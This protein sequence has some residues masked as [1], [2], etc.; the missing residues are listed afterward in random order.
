MPEISEATAVPQAL[1]RLRV[2]LDDAYNSEANELGL[3]AQQAEL[4]CA[5]AFHPVAVGELA[6]VLRCDRSNVSRL[7]DRIAQHDLVHRL[8]DEGDGRVSLIELSPRGRQLADAFLARLQSRT[9]RLVHTWSNERQRQ[10]SAMLIELAEALDN[11][12]DSGDA[13]PSSRLES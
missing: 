9:E 2:A 13:S 7:V 8:A 10:A 1:G 12:H 6:R 5:A 11:R 4:L 3:T